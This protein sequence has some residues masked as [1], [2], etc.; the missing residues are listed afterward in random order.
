MF[1]KSDNYNISN[2]VRSQKFSIVAP[3]LKNL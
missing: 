3:K 2:Y 1:I